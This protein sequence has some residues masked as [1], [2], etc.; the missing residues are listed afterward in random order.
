MLIMVHHNEQM[1]MGIACVPI[2]LRFTDYA[3]SALDVQPLLIAAVS[4]DNTGCVG[5]PMVG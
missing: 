4:R 2:V 1:L 5:D 3:S